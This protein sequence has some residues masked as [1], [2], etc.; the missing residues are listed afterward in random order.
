M[1]PLQNTGM[2]QLQAVPEAKQKVLGVFY[3]GYETLFACF[4]RYIHANSQAKI[5]AT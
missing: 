4:D 3:D 5:P 2:Y 1:I